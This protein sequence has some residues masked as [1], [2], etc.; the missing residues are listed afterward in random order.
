[1][2]HCRLTRL[3]RMLLENGNENQNINYQNLRSSNRVCDGYQ[4][5]HNRVAVSGH[6]PDDSHRLHPDDGDEDCVQDEYVIYPAVHHAYEIYYPDGVREEAD[7]HGCHA[8]DE[9]EDG[10]QVAWDNRDGTRGVIWEYWIDYFCKRGKLQW[11][12]GNHTVP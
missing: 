4:N 11:M 9:H 1:M 6:H 8:A 7:R 2:G 5:R 10:G 3:P 12:Y